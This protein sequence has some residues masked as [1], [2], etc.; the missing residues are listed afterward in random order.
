MNFILENNAKVFKNNDTKIYEHNSIF[1]DY[2]E[3]LSR[4]LVDY[5]T[6]QNEFDNTDIY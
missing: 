2:D 1:I 5:D 3:I 4:K 6:I